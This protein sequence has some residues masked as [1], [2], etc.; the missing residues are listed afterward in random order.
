MVRR[1][2]AHFDTLNGSVFCFITSTRLFSTHGKAVNRFQDRSWKSWKTCRGSED[3]TPHHELWLVSLN[4][5]SPAPHPFISVSP[6]PPPPPHTLSLI[7]THTHTLVALSLSLP[8]ARFH[9]PPSKVEDEWVSVGE[10]VRLLMHSCSLIKLSYGGRKCICAPAA[11]APL[12]HRKWALG[13][14][15]I[16]LFQGFVQSQSSEAWSA[17]GPTVLLVHAQTPAT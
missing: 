15:P 7:Y 12:R 6:P 11:A 3:D 2:S 9:P 14:R 5:I 13:C 17:N 4:S 1:V 8:A 10:R 16:Q